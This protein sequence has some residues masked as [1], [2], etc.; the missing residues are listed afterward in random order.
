MILEMFQF[1]KLACG[2][3]SSEWQKEWHKLAHVCRRWRTIIFASQHG[4]DL[5]LLCTPKTSIEMT[6][7][8][9]PTFPIVV[10]YAYGS[11]S[12]DDRDNITTVLQQN[13]RICEID[14]DLYHPLSENESRI[15]QETFP[16]LECLTLCSWQGENLVLPDTFL[17]GSAPHLS[18]LHLYGIDFPALPQFLSSAS[19]L[20]D[21]LLHRIPSTGSLSSEA[22]ARG[23]SA[24][25]RLKTLSL[26]ITPATTH[27]NPRNAPP[28]SSGH[29]ILSALINLDL[30][31]PCHYLED[32]LSRISAPSLER[33]TI[34]FVVD[35][36]SFDISRLAQFLCRVE[37]QRSP[38]A[39][40]VILN[41]P[42][43]FVYLSPSGAEALS[44]SLP[45]TSSEWLSLDLTFQAP[46]ELFQMNQI[47]QQLSPFLSGVRALDINTAYCQL[48]NNLL[49]E[50]FHSFSRVERLYVSGIS[51]PKIASALQ[52]D[53]AIMATNVLPALREFTLD[54][55]MDDLT[56]FSLRYEW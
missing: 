49:W 54:P 7:D 26:K 8:L 25:P 48:D 31:G 51:A 13:D 43:T 55:G 10:Q 23:L 52:F 30:E 36:P 15:M 3:D 42:D 16:L 20:V 46:F 33:A 45:N 56:S 24:A 34:Q 22:L 17:N 9:W 50:I 39:A 41:L 27:P 44:A 6:L 28:S 40:Q 38:D 35:Q 32:L 1:Y 11:L 14:L 4:L 18:A 5:R 47:C 21:L 2:P 53:S 19:D 12:P 29:L 37:S